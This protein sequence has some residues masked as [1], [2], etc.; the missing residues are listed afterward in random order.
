MT[1]Y[2]KRIT[3]ILMVI[4]LLAYPL[5]GFTALSFVNVRTTVG[6]GWTYGTD[7]QWHL[8][9]SGEKAEFSPGEKV[10]FFAQV[11]PIYV[12]HQWRLLLLR[13]GVQFR[14]LINDRFNPVSGGWNY[15][16]FVPFMTDLAAGNYQADYY[17][18]VGAGFEK[19]ASVAFHVNAP[20]A[21]YY[22][23]HAVTSAGWDYGTGVGADHWNLRPVDQR[24]VFNVGETVYLMTQTR[25]VNVSHRYKSELYRSSVKL[26]EHSTAWLNVGSG[27]QYSNYYPFYANAQPGNFEFRVFIDLGSGW[28]S[29]ATT[30][31]MVNG[32][33][34]PFV[35]DR[36][37]VATGWQHGTSSDYW[38]LQPV[39]A[40][41]VFNPGETVYALSLVKNIY[42]NHQWKGELYRSGTFL[43]D[44]VTPWRD[45]GPGWSFGSYY[46]Y[47]SNAQPGNYEWKIY[48]NSGNGF[49][50]LD[51]KAFN[52]TG[53]AS[54]YNYV[55]STV[56]ENWTYGTSTDFWNIQPVNPRTLFNAG[57]NVFLVTQARDVRVNHR[58][59][60]ETY[61]EG[62]L[63]WTHTTPLN[64]VGS[65]WSYSNFDPANYNSTIGNYQFK[66][67]LDVGTGFQLMDTK[68]FSVI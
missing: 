36:T 50:L 22:F 4:S 14:E 26:W 42:V 68:S 45:V 23:D 51:T 62:T 33:I 27:W 66:V 47:Y 9:P 1:T 43:W 56:A 32:A 7:E 6:T 49:E 59:K 16:N 28:Q 44:N 3:G 20:I 30:S 21:S 5:A 58:W 48:L 34:V 65:G 46:P 61:R 40:K 25:N 41:T 52:V 63:L 13:D 55:G 64:I 35:Y 29:L 38:N 37:Y 57:A 31:F 39:N 67:Y 8:Q 18:D 24:N 15:S 10:Q 60:V 54:D 2:L 12:S 53:T 11:G 19:L 17:L